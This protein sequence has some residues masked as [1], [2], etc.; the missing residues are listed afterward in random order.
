[1]KALLIEDEKDVAE[2]FEE[3]LKNEGYEVHHCSNG[4]TAGV[5][6]LDHSG[7]GHFDLIVTDI[8]IPGKSGSDLIEL[9]ERIE[10]MGGSL[11]LSF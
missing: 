8:K 2:I 6:I 9:L 7:D 11:P 3:W 5:E 1:M 10:P 4:Y